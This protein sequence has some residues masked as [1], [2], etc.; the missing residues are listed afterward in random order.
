[1]IIKTGGDFEGYS[2]IWTTT[3]KEHSGWRTRRHGGRRELGCCRGC[4][5]H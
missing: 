4:D 1:V 2:Q 3:S 5:A